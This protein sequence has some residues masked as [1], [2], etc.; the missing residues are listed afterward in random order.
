MAKLI[1]HGSLVFDIGAN[2]G[3][4]AQRFLDAGADKVVCV[5]PCFEVF[6]QLALVKGIVPI[7]AAVW[8]TSKLL[9]VSYC[10]NHDGWSSC[11]PAEWSLMYPEADWREPQ[12]VPTVTL[13]HLIE[14]FGMPHLLKVDVEKAEM[15]ALAGLSQRPPFLIYEFHQRFVE[16]ALACLDRCAALGFTRA[17]YTCEEIDINTVPTLPLAKFRDKFIADAPV[18]GQISVA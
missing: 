2:V 11:K 9:P 5:E 16:D 8:N 15:E 12:W 4:M 10:A 1:P 17:H 18:W 7:H 13:D 3:Q 14:T 6:Q